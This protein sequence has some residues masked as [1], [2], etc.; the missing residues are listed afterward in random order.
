MKKKTII[1]FYPSDDVLD[2]LEQLFESWDSFA[3]GR[4]F[5]IL[6][7]FGRWNGPVPHG[8]PFCSLRELAWFYFADRFDLS[9]GPYGRLFLDAW[10]HDGSNHYEI[11]VLTPKGERYLESH[12]GQ[13]RYDLAEKLFSRGYSRIPHPEGGKEK[14]I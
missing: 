6:G 12:A 4:H 10:H 7:T 11:R 8:Q 2:G 9:K 5:V 14:Q 1:S 13:R 3:R